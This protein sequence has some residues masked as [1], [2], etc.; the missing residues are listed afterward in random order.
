MQA[1]WMDQASDAWAI[2][3]VRLRLGLIAARA[4]L[5]FHL[6]LLF[7]RVYVFQ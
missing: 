6:S 3:A 4:T 1:G 5:I 7:S 2:W